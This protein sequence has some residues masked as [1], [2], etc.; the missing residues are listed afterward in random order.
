M[1]SYINFFIYFF[2]FLHL[3]ILKISGAKVAREELP[4]PGSQPGEFVFVIGG[5]AAGKTSFVPFKRLREKDARLKK[6]KE[7]EKRT[8]EAGGSQRAA[9]RRPILIADQVACGVFS[10]VGCDLSA[11]KIREGYF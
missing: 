6:K 1:I 10:G 7:E 5:I 9:A 8:G 4:T 2:R 11:E 3:C